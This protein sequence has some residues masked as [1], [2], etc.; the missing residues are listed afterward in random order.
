[1]TEQTEYS[2]NQRQEKLIENIRGIYRVDA[3]A[4]TGK[5]FTLTRRY[6]HILRTTDAQPS[7]LLLITFTRNAA[8]E[9]KERVL[10]RCRDEVDPLDLQE[11]PMTTFHGLCQRILRRDGFEAPRHLGIDN[12]LTSSTKLLENRILELQEFRDFIRY[13]KEHHTEYRDFLRLYNSPESLLDLIKSLASK[14]IFPTENGWYQQGEEYL[15]G[16][17]EEF[18]EIFREANSPGGED[19]N[20]QSKLRDKLNRYDDKFYP[21]GAPGKQD[22]RGPRNQKQIGDEWCEKA[23]EED[24]ERLK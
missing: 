15:D 10:I 17:Q 12:Y 7:E 19:S 3:G 24:R 9:M 23:F 6:A 18:R 1:M 11:A 8:E 16:R 5:T 13:F 2:P 20:R 4:G 22:I 21:P 14:G